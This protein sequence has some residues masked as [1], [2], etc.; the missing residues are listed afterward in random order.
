[1]SEQKINLYPVI[2]F[3]LFLV[4]GAW[5]VSNYGT[6]GTEYSGHLSILTD[7][8]DYHEFTV[9]IATSPEKMKAG[10]MFRDSLSEDHGM[11]FVYP[12]IGETAMWMKNTKIPLD[13]LFIDAT[14]KIVHVHENAH[15]YD[16]TPIPSRFPV[17]ATLEIKGGQ[18]ALLGIKAGDR[19]ESPF[20]KDAN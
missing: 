11:L 4:G 3:F 6:H 7:N 18:A 10:L 2:I 1:M 8:G 19:V 13:M 14:G 15:P 12:N 20:F 5:F 9:E 16:E 17:K